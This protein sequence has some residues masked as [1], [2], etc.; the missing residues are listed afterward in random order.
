VKKLAIKFNTTLRRYCQL[1]T[2]YPIVFFFGAF[3]IGIMFWGMF[4]FSLEITNTEEFCIG[5]HEMQENVYLEYKKTIHYANRTGVRATCPDC[6]VPREWLHKVIR[7]VG[8]TNELFHKIIGSID[9]PDKFYAKRLQL[10][11]SV[12]AGMRAT[13][14]RECRNCHAFDYMSL[15][16]QRVSSR[17][18]HRSGIENNRTCIDCHMGI[19]HA[20]SKDFDKDG[21]L[22]EGFRREKRPCSDCHK[23]MAQAA[24]WD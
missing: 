16:S 17:N 20:I 15:K 12:W 4:N 21:R 22:H 10:A 13:D 23:D 11:Q 24:S 9:T 14:S 19:A 2:H 8:A 7:K 3:I 6:H 5:C 18:A 1:G